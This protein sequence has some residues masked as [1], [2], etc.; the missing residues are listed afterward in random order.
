MRLKD[1]VAVVT[2][3]GSGIGKKIAESFLEEGAKV[4]FSDISDNQ[5]TSEEN[6]IYIKCDVSDSEQVSQLIQK[7][8]EKFGKIDVIVN[9]AGVGALGGILDVTNEGWDKVI[10]VNLSGTMY[11]MRETAKEMKKQGINGS[12]INISSILGKVGF[13]GALAYC[14][15]KGGV[16]QLTRAGAVD[17][18]QDKIR[19]NAIAP[20]FIR[21]KMTEDV[22][23]DE[24]FNNLVTSST[25]LGHVGEVDDIANA[26]IYLASDEAKYVTGEVLYVDGGWT[27]K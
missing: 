23:K 3:A 20:G 24:G 17:L 6:S 19:V 22:L 15:S 18:A 14:A 7:T 1:K 26:A 4:V 8:V 9:N 13:N 5:E 10:G 21:T 27:A 12:I 25:L 2:G 16:V 11:G